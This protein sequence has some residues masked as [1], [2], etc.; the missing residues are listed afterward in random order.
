MLNLK[1][2]QKDWFNIGKPWN[3]LTLL[4]RPFSTCQPI[5]V[6]QS[7]ALCRNGMDKNNICINID[8][9]NGWWK[10]LHHNKFHDDTAHKC[11]RQN[12]SISLFRRRIT[13]SHM[14]SSCSFK[15]RKKSFF[16]LHTIYAFFHLVAIFV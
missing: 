1:I 6:H 14:C 3:L 7:F 5:C 10:E 11:Q 9:W 4:Q 8:D 16:H 12:S 2:L 13:I 15:E